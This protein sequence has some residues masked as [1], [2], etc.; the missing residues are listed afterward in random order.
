MKRTKK[1]IGLLIASI[2]FASCSTTDNVVSKYFIQKRKY[3]KG[4]Y[5]SLKDKK[6]SEIDISDKS[7]K[8]LQKDSYQ[9][10]PFSS[11]YGNTNK[12]TVNNNYIASTD[13]N[14]VV[15]KNNKVSIVKDNKTNKENFNS[16][17]TIKNKKLQKSKLN[18]LEKKNSSKVSTPP[19]DSGKSQLVALILVIF[20]GALGIHRFYL[21]Y[22]GIGII[23]LL[24][25]G[26]CGIWTLIDL[27]RIAT[28]DLK[29]A[30][31]DYSETL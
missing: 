27:I 14:F 26:G 28:G 25:A 24:T 15:L 11:I 21:G 7:N 20:A 5:L 30:D 23:Q 2:F 8:T 12:P 1:L 17:S 10:S 29:P 3:N 4:Y 13:A 18:K 16:H 22:T 9:E 31:G 6:Q 19:G